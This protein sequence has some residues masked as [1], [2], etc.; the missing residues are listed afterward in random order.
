[1][2]YASRSIPIRQDFEHYRNDAFVRDIYLENVDETDPENPIVTAVDFTGKTAKMQ[3]K[4]SATGAALLTLTNGSGL[5]YGADGLITVTITKAQMTA[6]LPQNA[7]YVYDLQL[8]TTAT[9]VDKTY[10]AGRFRLVQDIT[11]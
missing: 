1:M 10:L 9:G 5:V 3:I 4:A 11:T 2:S 7:V 6:S 8:T